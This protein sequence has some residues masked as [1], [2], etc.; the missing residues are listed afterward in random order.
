MKYTFV[1]STNRKYWQEIAE[2]NL[3]S[4]DKFLPKD[5]SIH[6]FS[7]DKIDHN[8]LS[9]R[10]LFHNLYDESPDLLNFITKYKDNPHLNNPSTGTKSFKWKGVKFAHK[11]YSIFS[12]KKYVNDGWLIWL[13]NDILIHETVTKEYLSQILP[14]SSSVVYLGRPSM[15][16]ECGFVGYN[17][18]KN[19]AHVFL[20]KF[21]A[22][23]NSGEIESLQETHDSYVFDYVRNLLNDTSF[24]NLNKHSETNKPPFPRTRLKETMVHTKGLNKDKLQNKFLKK[25]QQR[26]AK[27]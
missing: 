5:S 11:T 21:E 2:Y 22:V 18:N 20:E 17:L 10:F 7:E 23:Y 1:T 15:Y 14:S 25:L 3:K 16:S 24:Y 19:I 4:W 9:S 26:K 8:N 27:S 12:A 13:D 6:V